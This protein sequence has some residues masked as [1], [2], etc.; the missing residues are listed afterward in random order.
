MERL[1]SMNFWEKRVGIG[2]EIIMPHLFLTVSALLLMLLPLAPG[3]MFGSEGDWY[4]QHVGAAEALRQTILSTGTIFPQ[5]VGIGGGANA[6]DLAYYGLFRPDVLISCLFPETA[7]RTVISVYAAAG[8][9]A[10]VNFTYLWLKSKKL[11][12]GFSLCGG[13][14]MACAACFFHAHHQ[15]M[16]V[17][18]MPF[19]VL[20]L[21]AIDR[22]VDKKGTLP[23]T[24]C[25]F[26]ICI[27]SFFYAPTCL[28]VSLLYGLHQL[29]RMPGPAHGKR[30]AQMVSTGA[31]AAAAAIL[32]IGMAAVLL[33]P[34]GLDILSTSKDAGVFMDRSFPA[35]SLTFNGL[36]YQPYGCGMT[37][38]ALYCLLLSL[39][40]KRKRFLSA[41]ILLILAVP[42]VWLALSGFLYPRE[43]I[44][45]PLV[46]L[47][48]WLCA[49]TLQAFYRGEQKA[50]ILPALF[51]LM[52]VLLTEG[53]RKTLMLMDFGLIAVW[54]LLTAVKNTPQKVR[55]AALAVLLLV[56]V[57]TSYGVNCGEDYLMK[58]DI[59]QSRFSFGDITVFAEDDRYRFDYLANNYINSNVL[60]D[61]NLNKTASYLSVTNNLYSGFCYDTMR[62]P[63]SLRNRVVLMPNRNSLFNYFMGIRYVLTEEDRIPYGYEMVFRRN[64]YVLAEN[65]DV[66]PVCYGTGR[67]PSEKALAQMEFPENVAA[68]CGVKVQKE[69][70]SAFFKE[71]FPGNYEEAAALSAK[72]TE[73]GDS[74]TVRCTLPLSQVVK[75]RVLIISFDLDRKDGRETC[76]TINGMK[77]NLSGSNA[78]YPNENKH[79]TFILSEEKGIESLEME[80]TRGNYQMKNL[81]VFT[82]AIPHTA[83]ADITLPTADK[84]FQKDGQKVYKGSIEMDRDGYFVTSYPWKEGYRV[85]VD[86]ED[87]KAEKVNTAFLGFPLDKGKHVIQIEFCAPGFFP[88][89]VISLISLA[90]AALL[91]AMESMGKEKKK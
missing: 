10:S 52:P 78:P 84:S 74:G 72:E 13:Q 8:V 4:S 6:Y 61:G 83:D 28:V 1:G 66:L 60:P 48:V 42:A 53:D 82:S 40:S 22:I 77:N 81:T 46:P 21:W 31:R 67:V 9:I 87:V 12:T 2:I 23:L 71:P 17:N 44:L 16:F 38:L 69:N 33:L 45:I 49:D 86:G 58:D 55:Q 62:N 89:A 51:C 15:I 25:V 5:F 35:V 64:G 54:M 59:R 76:I 37:M 75:D 26:L 63:I 65:P 3:T 56:P 7:M 57:C 11:S 47:V 85:S 73:Q 80:L 39:E 29:F 88:G 32:G 36:L 18:Y 90:A 43:K 24:L 50:R 41:A 79:F 91:A 68:L 20:A 30:S 19:L 14:L 70:P 27:H 34:A